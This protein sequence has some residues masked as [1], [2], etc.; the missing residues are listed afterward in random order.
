M[1]LSMHPGQYTLINAKKEEIFRNSVK[2]LEYH[3][4][5]LDLMKTPTNTKIQIHVG[6]VYGD[7][8]A[9][10]E[11]FVKRYDDLP[12]KVRKR[13]VIENDEKSYSVK[14]CMSIGERLSI[15]IVFDSLHHDTKNN[16]ES[17]AQA[18]EITSKT[19]YADDGL[20]MIDYSSQAEGARM[21]RHS[22]SIRLDHFRKFLKETSNYDFDIML[23]IKDKESSALKALEMA[24][25]DSRRAW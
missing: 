18:I 6:G 24:K 22:E 15:P 14:D 10:I 17:Y 13:L 3:A 9:S 19:W 23:E 25:D 20:P 11:R 5:V 2:E 7:K 16:G 4:E 1:R 8:V 12:K 21:G